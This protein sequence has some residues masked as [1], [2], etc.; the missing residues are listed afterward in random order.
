MGI[1]VGRA[2][3]VP[4]G[5]RVVPIG[6]DAGVSRWVLD[7]PIVSVDHTVYEGFFPLRTQPKETG[8]TLTLDQFMESTQPW[9]SLG[10]PTKTLGLTVNW[11]S[12]P[13]R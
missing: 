6:Y 9:L 8:R 11:R 5:I 12:Q 2:D 1:Y 4:G 7:K 13:N 3:E 10:Y